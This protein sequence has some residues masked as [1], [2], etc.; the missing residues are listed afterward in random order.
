LPRTCLTHCA[1]CSEGWDPGKTR[2]KRSV[3][4]WVKDAMGLS[5][6]EIATRLFLSPRTV[7]YHL[8]KVFTKL[9]ITSRTQLT[10]V[11]PRG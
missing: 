3:A 2:I 5:N 1:G 10:R 4:L 8:G 6:P 11:L 9:D 7:Q